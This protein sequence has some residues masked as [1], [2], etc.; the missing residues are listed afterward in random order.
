MSAAV[1]AFPCADL[2]CNLRLPCPAR[3]RCLF[4]GECALVCLA[5]R[6]LVLPRKGTASSARLH[7]AAGVLKPSRRGCREAL[8][9]I[10]CPAVLSARRTASGTNTG[11][12]RDQPPSGKRVEFAG[13]TLMRFNAAGQIHQSLVFRWVCC[14]GRGTVGSAC[15]SLLC[16]DSSPC[17]AAT[18][19][20]SR[21]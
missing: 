5:M 3:T 9:H 8:Q 11:P 10:H 19:A 14:E 16:V 21:G 1:P 18:Q 7:R 12:I 13:M 2:W 4:T 17:A 20:S 6:I 15:A